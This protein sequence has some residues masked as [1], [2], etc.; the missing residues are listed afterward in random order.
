LAA[1][2]TYDVFMLVESRLM[3]ADRGQNWYVYVLTSSGN[4]YMPEI[5]AISIASLRLAQPDARIAML[6][7][8]ETSA[9]TSPGLTAIRPFIDNFVVVD[10]PGH[11]PLERSRYL[12]T[13]VRL[14]LP[15]RLL[16]L[17]CDTIIMRSPKS[18]WDL[19]ADVAASPDLLSGGKFCLA[20]EK[21]AELTE[22]LGWRLLP[23]TYLNTGVVF[24]SDSKAS[25]AVGDQMHRSW[26]E[27][28]RATGK[29]NDQPALN[30][31][32]H[33]IEPKLLVLPLVYNAQISMNVMAVRG[34]I[35]VHY[36]TGTLA[37][38]EDI[39]AHALAKRLKHDDILDT[40]A[41]AAAIEAGNPWTSIDSY[42]KAI[43]TRRFASIGKVAFSRLSKRP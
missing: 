33:T 39:I 12:K 6:S 41:L 7:D 31:A 23:R 36:F 27:Y 40:S 10:C 20:S 16:Y 26:T 13:S 18:T 8:R 28:S 25:H 14:L 5:A 1:D 15:G 42:R 24:Y 30:H 17:D 34:A 37:N 29:Y 9:I 3:Q 32:I 21:L 11:S 19:E 2:K 43:A 38:S 35:I 22:K 4:D